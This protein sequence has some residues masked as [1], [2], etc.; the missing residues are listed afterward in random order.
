MNILV[1]YQGST[2][3]LSPTGFIDEYTANDFREKLNELIDSGVRT[4]ELDMAGVDFMDSTGI[5]V[6]LSRYKIMKSKGI[7]MQLSHCNRQV[8]KLFRLTGIY[9]IIATR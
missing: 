8:D 3:T 6:L 2:A 1:R 9:S 4:V 7:T 5:G